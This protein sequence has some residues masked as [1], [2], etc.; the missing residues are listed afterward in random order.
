[1]QTTTQNETATMLT[2]AVRWLLRPLIRILI[3]KGIGYPQLR[4]LLK[5]LYVEVA[6]STF[7][8]DDNR[9]TDSRIHILTGVHRKD[10]RRL[11]APGQEKKDADGHTS[12]LSGA[13][14]SR[15]ASLPE[16]QDKNGQPRALPRT[17]MGG[18]PSF[19]ALVT[20]VSKDVRPR[21]ILDELQRQELVSLDDAGNIYLQASAFM[22]RANFDEQTFF[23]GRNVHDHLA[24]CTH[25]LLSDGTPMLERSVYFSHLGEDSVQQLRAM[26]EDHARQLLQALN[27]Q[28]Q[29]FEK[30]DQG[31]PD[32]IHRIRF[33]CYWFHAQRSNERDN[34]P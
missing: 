23:M 4:E 34:M 5:I 22:P 20:T 33:G 26:A 17:A 24:A 6:E 8:L 14:V 12:T 28:A 29:T 15:W 18:T 16:Y 21:A 31:K 1:M 11:R 2:S 9:P 32:A 27:D 3:E 10:I 7:A 25:N 30:S 13:I 19:E